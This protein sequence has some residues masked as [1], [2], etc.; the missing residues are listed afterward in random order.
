MEAELARYLAHRLE[1]ASEVTISNL[2]RIPGGASRETWRFDASWEVGG[3]AQSEGFI[4][5]KDPPAS[6]VESDRAVEYAFYGAF[7]GTSVPVPRMR[8]LEEEASH[9]GA[10]FFIMERIDGCE[11][12]TRALQTPAFDASRD[13]VA[14]RFYAILAE[15]GRLPWESSPIAA[16]MGAPAPG[17]CW[18]RELGYWEGMIDAN[19]LSPQPIARAA[20]R[21]LRANPPPPPAHVGP[22]HGDYRVGN[23]LYTREGEIRAILDWEMA[24]LGDPLEDLA[25]S[26]M[27]LWEWGRSGY[28]GGIVL[29]E[30]AIRYYEEAAGTTV[31]RD[32][33]HWW[34]VFSCVKGQGIWLT[35]ARSFQEGRSRELIHAF[36]S[37]N[38]INTQDEAILRAM[39]RGA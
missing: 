31:D 17:D 3:V 37:H 23:F 11:A 35:G 22:V 33:L 34:L 39:G 13:G 4:V 10:P 16:V 25:W 26:F 27:E 24:H 29:T 20:I 12:N 15:I 19:E 38:L 14:R 21:W 1:G 6:L 32:A 36:T 30:D 2:S 8:W 28:P 5:R 9:L 18:K 7:E